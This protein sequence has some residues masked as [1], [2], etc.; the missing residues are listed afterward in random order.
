MGTS[1]FVYYKASE[2]T[3]ELIRAAYLSGLSAP[4]VARRFGVT[5]TALRKR[6]SRQGWTK[7]K[8]AQALAPG[9]A[10]MAPVKLAPTAVSLD[11]DG[12]V[13]TALEEAARALA[14]GRPY[15]ARACATAGEAMAR[16]IA[17]A[18]DYISADTV[19][20]AQARQAYWNAA[21][22]E[23]A[24]DLAD[25]LLRGEPLPEQH[26]QAVARWRIATGRELPVTVAA[27]SGG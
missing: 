13:K 8:H 16:L 21:I 11:P 18:P 7:A 15:Q 12:L 23:F 17:R 1:P 2:A 22:G 14:D 19:S 10:A 27:G 3:W 20:E 9:S 4:V 26:A 6:A 5:L 25:K 24:V